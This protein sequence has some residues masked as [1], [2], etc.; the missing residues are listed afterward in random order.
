MLANRNEGRAPDGL[1]YRVLTLTNQRGMQIQVTDWGATWL[2]CKVPV[3]NE[4]REVLIGCQL[5]DY[6][7]Q[8]AY[9]GATVGRFANRIANSKFELNGKQVH[10]STNQGLHQLHGGVKGFDKQRWNILKEGDDFVR[11]SLISVD[12]EEGFMGNVEV[13][14][15]YFLTEDNAV[16]IH[17]DAI[18]DQ[19]TP[20]N[21]TNH[22]YFNLENATGGSDVRQHR[23]QINASH[24]LPVDCQGIPNA[25]LKSLANTSFDFTQGKSIAQDFL[26]E[27][28]QIVKGYDH[29][30]LLHHIPQQECAT[31][32]AP[33]NSL[34]LQ[35]FTSQPALQVYTGNF[36]GG[37]P[38]RDGSEYADYAGIALETQALPD[39]PNH[40]EW[41]QYGGISKVNERYQHW[42]VFKF[43]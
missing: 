5:E 30:F 14:V 23:L 43:I 25:P 32:S 10:L 36:L 40:P 22:A 8:Q 16:E 38:K 12:G 6:P 28:Q 4:L 7:V 9:L 15:T 41:W 34:R 11:F 26:Q 31:L 35:I 24:Y 27:E 29:S 21:L 20:L 19:D 2:S 1:P 39:T 18:S 42:T 17:F 37:T 3:K 13:L 33:D